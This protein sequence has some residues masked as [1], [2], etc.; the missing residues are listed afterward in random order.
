MS[1]DIDSVIGLE[2]AN[3]EMDK[4]IHENAPK[5]HFKPMSFESGDYDSYESDK[6]VCEHCGHTKDIDP[7]IQLR[8]E[9][10]ND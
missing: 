8:K 10:S 2:K 5:C 6:W 9:Q 1:Y 7:F 4:A 3:V